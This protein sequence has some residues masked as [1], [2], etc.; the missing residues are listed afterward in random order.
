MAARSAP[1]SVRYEGYGPG[2]VAVLID[3]VTRDRDRTVTALRQAFAVHGG[4]LGAEGAVRYLFNASGV[5]VLPPGVNARAAAEAAYAAGAEDVVAM[6]DGTLEVLTDPAEIETIRARLSAAGFEPNSAG[7][8]QRAANAVALEGECALEAARLFAALGD[9]GDVRRV[10]SNA[11]IPDE[12]L[13][14]VSA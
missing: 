10:Y 5:M 4:H 12:I 8:T 1:A 11:S 14:R 9:L 2:G 7:V 3:C 13:A 6:K